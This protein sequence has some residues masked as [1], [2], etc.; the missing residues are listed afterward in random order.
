MK[1]RKI[2]TVR[3]TLLQHGSRLPSAIQIDEP[4][5]SLIVRGDLMRI[6]CDRALSRQRYQEFFSSWKDAEADLPA[7]IEAKKEFK[8]L[9][10]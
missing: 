8:A 5:R 3:E 2:G 7:L 4:R 6:Q 1:V 10:Q 9:P